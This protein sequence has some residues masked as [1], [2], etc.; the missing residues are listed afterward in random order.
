MIVPPSAGRKQRPNDRLG[1]TMA[2]AISVLLAC[3]HSGVRPVGQDDDVHC[4]LRVDDQCLSCPTDVR[5]GPRRQGRR[6]DVAGVTNVPH[7]SLG[8]ERLPDLFGKEPFA[9]TF[10]PTQPERRQLRKVLG[11]RE[12][13]AI[14]N[15]AG[16]YGGG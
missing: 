10:S 15:R 9:L 2:G 13:A 7:D 6:N 1:D 3:V 11:G 4:P 8:R 16:R 5:A 14:A 12:Q